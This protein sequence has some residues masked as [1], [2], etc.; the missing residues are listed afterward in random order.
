MVGLAM[1]DGG[2]KAEFGRRGK[3]DEMRMKASR[4]SEEARR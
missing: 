3:E 2:R 4:L 1:D